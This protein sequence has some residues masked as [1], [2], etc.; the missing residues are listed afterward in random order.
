V[1]NKGS[2]SVM[3]QTQTVEQERTARRLKCLPP[4][5]V[6]RISLLQRKATATNK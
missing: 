6:E 5:A 1:E 2:H 4:N 3:T